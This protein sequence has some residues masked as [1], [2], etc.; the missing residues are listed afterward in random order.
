M[1]ASSEKEL[2]RKEIRNRR[3]EI[4]AREGWKDICMAMQMRLLASSRWGAAENVVLYSA[5]KGE[6]DT[7]LLFEQAWKSGKNVFLPRCRP[8]REGEMDLVCCSSFRNLVVSSF[9]IPEP[10]LEPESRVLLPQDMGST[11][12]LVVAPALTFDRCGYRLGYGGGYYDRLLSKSACPTVGLAYDELLAWRLPA[13][14]WDRSV[15]AVYTEHGVF[16]KGSRAE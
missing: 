6:P 7:L 11:A 16:E 2:L 14:P 10:V 1:D 9:G 15:D 5:V 4:A 3:K 13:D 8:G 12:T